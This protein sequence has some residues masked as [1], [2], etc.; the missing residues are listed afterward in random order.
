MALTPKIEIRQSQSLLMTPQLR[1]AINL[2]QLSNLEL[3]TLIESELISNPLLE[4]EDERLENFDTKEQTIDD[5]DSPPNS[6][7]LLTEEEFKPDVDYDNNFTDDFGS[8]REGYEY[9]SDC[10]WQDYSEQKNQSNQPSPD[11]D[12]FEQHLAAEKTLYQ[13]LNE[14]ISIHFHQPKER[15]I[16]SVLVE[17]LDSSGYFRGDI[18]ILANRLKISTTTIQ[19]ILNVMKTFE[20]SGIFAENLAEC[21][22]IQLQDKNRL[23]CLMKELLQHLDLLGERKFKEL[24]K[25]LNIDDEDLLSLISDI[26]STNPKPA[27]IYNSGITS[28]I[29]PDVFVRQ[30]KQHNY[31]VEL[32]NLSLPRVLINQEYYHEIKE[33]GDK[34]KETHKYLKN[35]L[36]NAS[37]LVKALHQRATTILR[38][39]EEIVKFQS[40]FFN[41]GIN[42]LKPLSLKD[43]AEAV[44]M[45]EST[46]SRVTNNKYMHTPLGIFE[47]KYF[48]SSAAGSYI[49]N[50]NTSVLS[51]KHKIKHLIEK[52]SPEN[53]LSDDKISELL[54]MEGLKV[55]RRTIAKYRESLNIPTSGERKK[56]KHR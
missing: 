30:N 15:I 35:Q 51:L 4:R 1:Q 38:V 47:L 39:S 6:D 45:H 44:E 8:D 16:A 21:I 46:I 19:K 56:Q 26:K 34:Q 22:A 18:T 54:A 53:I 31:V 55:A 7:N 42:Y 11:Y 20:P 28:Y 33:L 2:L 10:N 9:N 5:Y 3:N 40:A 52:E 50:D 43:I 41:K 25:L 37:F 14:Q 13:I 49:G 36:S 17:Y 12:F 29:I 24:K 48:F 27:A 32:N 23:D